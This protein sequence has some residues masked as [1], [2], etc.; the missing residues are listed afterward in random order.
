[1]AKFRSSFGSG[2]FIKKI[3]MNVGLLVSVF[4]RM[5]P[6]THLK[7]GGK[8]LPNPPRCRMRKLSFIQRNGGSI[9]LFSIFRQ[10]T[11]SDG[12]ENE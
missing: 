7:I 3:L 9:A 4:E 2:T 1:M 6:E 10:E 8:Y 5:S 12:N 11:F